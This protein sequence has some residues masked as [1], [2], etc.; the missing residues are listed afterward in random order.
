MDNLT[1]KVKNI[2]IRFESI[3][4]KWDFSVGIVINKIKLHTV[5]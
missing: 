4:R 5:N 1:I 3:Q 2:H